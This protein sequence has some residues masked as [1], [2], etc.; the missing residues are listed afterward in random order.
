M[1]YVLYLYV[2]VSA[3][4]RGRLITRGFSSAR[5]SPTSP[6]SDVA[7]GIGAAVLRGEPAPEPAGIQ[8]L[9]LQVGDRQ[10]FWPA[11]ILF[12]F[13]SVVPQRFACLG[14]AR[15]GE[16]QTRMQ[17]IVCPFVFLPESREQSLII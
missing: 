13:N 2:E 16:A 4:G 8:G 14:V 12:A 5:L 10:A 6:E 15:R 7:C 3:R 11:T 17:R 9:E 1:Y